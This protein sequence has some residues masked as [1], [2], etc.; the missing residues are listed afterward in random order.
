MPHIDYFDALQTKIVWKKWP[1]DFTVS[2]FSLFHYGSSKELDVCWA[3]ERIAR[4]LKILLIYTCKRYLHVRIVHFNH[5]WHFSVGISFFKRVHGIS[6]MSSFWLVNA[7]ISS[8][9]IPHFVFQVRHEYWKFASIFNGPTD[10]SLV[11]NLMHTKY[12]EN[13]IQLHLSSF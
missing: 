5:S 13:E 9:I 1:T 8:S 10:N 3:N 7:E 4:F 11:N 2:F 12:T 6:V